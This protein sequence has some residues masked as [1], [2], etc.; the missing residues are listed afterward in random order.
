V[1]PEYL[2]IENYGLIG[3]CGTAALVSDD[4][5][6]DWL[7]LPRFDS[8]PTYGR[9]LDPGGGHFSLRPEE[10]FTSTRMYLPDT[11]I[12][13][14]TFTTP[15]GKA[16]LYD[17]FAARPFGDK[18]THLWP[19]RY[20]VRRVEGEEGSVSFDVEVAPKDPFGGHDFRV[21]ASGCRLYAS[22]RGLDL[23]YEAT[24][25]FSVHDGIGR[26]KIT[27]EAGQHAYVTMAV[28]FGAIGVLPPVGGFA[29]RAYEETLQ[30]WK[31]WSEKEIVGGRA[32]EPVRRSALTLK[33]L[34]FAPSGGAVA[35]PTTSLPEQ[36]GG[37]RNWDYRY[38]WVRD[39][40][41]T[42]VA[43]FDLGYHD[44]AHAYMF[45]VTNA[46]HLTRPRIYTMYGVHGEH[47]IPEGD[48][49]PLR[50]YR[51]SRPVR[52]GNAALEQLQLDNWGQLVDAAFVFA[53][54]SGEMDSDMW[55]AIRSLVEWVAENWNQPDHGI[56]EV[57]G[58]PQH[59]VHSKVMCWVALDR[60]VRLVQDFHFDGPDDRWVRARDEVK[61]AILEHGYDQKR[62]TFV[63]TFGDEVVD[64]ALLEIPV[65]G[66][67]PG[68]DER[69][70]RT[71]DRIRD[72]LGHG[73]LVYRYLTDDNLPGDEGAFLPCSFWLVE[74]LAL[75]GRYD[76]ACSLFDRLCELRNDAGL[77]PEEIDPESGQ[78]LGNFPQGLSHIAL[79]NAASILRRLGEGR[80][81]AGQPS[82]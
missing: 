32:P 53:E 5:S 70:V 72:E 16:T 51:D 19:F 78:F 80:E 18:R 55:K 2:P 68:D 47:R 1:R 39:A 43:L 29:E 33:L 66:F 50:G 27:V 60:G 42:V 26:A 61:S 30:Y 4:G 25:P 48:V 17:F 76:E 28:A 24:A 69:V 44:E 38:V 62:G 57:R 36:I 15:T 3:E 41:R 58:D 9:I 71:V 21:R 8:D 12:L 34:T 77:L 45:W 74:A 65:V 7:C 54:R 56:W 22:R 67:L 73:D 6:I 13:A 64:A 10:P 49:Q 79:V 46:I 11:P 75:G 37:S 63:R 14:T 59:Y 52:R 81:E 20:L 82:G 35:A 40:S 23:F 31:D